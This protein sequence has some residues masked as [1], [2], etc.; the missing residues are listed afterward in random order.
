[1]E[2]ITVRWV[3]LRLLDLN[4]PNTGLIACRP[5]LVM[6][7]IPGK[8]LVAFTGDIDSIDVAVH[9]MVK[10]VPLD[11]GFVWP[12]IVRH[13]IGTRIGCMEEKIWNTSEGVAEE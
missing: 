4:A 12:H 11:Q 3:H 13:Y 10:S 9:N 8:L 7:D 5:G 6:L 2:A 1:M